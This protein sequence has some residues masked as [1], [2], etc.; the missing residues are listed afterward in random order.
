MQT[1]KRVLS[2]LLSGVMVFSLSAPSVYADDAV[3]GGITSTDGLCEHHPEHTEECGY[4][5][6][7]PEAPCTHEHTPDCYTQV[8]ECVHEHTPDCYPEAEDGASGE[9][10]REPENCAHVCSEESGCITKKLNCQHKHD[11]E[12]RYAP[13]IDG[14]PCGF[15]CEKCT[16]GKETEPVVPPEKEEEKPASMKKLRAVQAGDITN[17]GLEITASNP[18][19]GS[20]TAGEGT[21]DVTYNDETKTVTITMTNASIAGSIKVIDGLNAVVLLNGTNSISDDSAIGAIF[22]ETGAL[23]VNGQGTLNAVGRDY[24]LYGFNGITIETADI[25]ATSHTSS[26][27]TTAPI[28]ANNDISIIGSTI[29]TICPSNK[30]EPPNGYGIY[31]HGSNNGNIYISDSK[32]T[33]DCSLTAIYTEGSIEI[34]NTKIE[35]DSSKP[36]TLLYGGQGVTINN[37]TEITADCAKIVI[38]AI[39]DIVIDNSSMTINSEQSNGLYTTGDI[40]VQNGASVSGTCYYPTIYATNSISINNSTVNA[41]SNTNGIWTDGSLKVENSSNVTADG[42]YTGIG[43]LGGITI[44]NSAVEASGEM[45]FG[46]LT[47]SDIS[48][49]GDKTNV[50][51]KN[52]GDVPAVVSYGGNVDISGGV[53]NFSNQSDYV[54]CVNIYG[55]FTISGGQTTITAPGNSGIDLS[56]GTKVEITGGELTVNSKMAGIN[57]PNDSVEI[58]AGKVDITST[59]YVGILGQSV[60]ISGGEVSV[61]VS[62]NQQPFWVDDSTV[63]SFTGGTLILPNAANNGSIKVGNEEFYLVT[64]NAQNGTEP[65]SALFKKDEPVTPEEPR[66]E[67]YIFDGWYDAIS[68]G[69]KWNLEEDVVTSHMTLYAHWTAIQH[70]VTVQADEHGTASASPTS[71]AQGE[72][73]TLTATPNSGYHFK[74]WQVVS[75]SVTISNNSFTMPAGDVTVKAIFEKDS[76]GSSGGSIFSYDGDDDEDD[77]SSDSSRDSSSTPVY[78]REILTGGG[79]ALSGNRVHQSARLTVTK[80]RLHGSGDCTYCDQIR[81]WRRQ[82]RVIAIYDVAL[83]RGFRGT[84]TLTFPVPSQ[85][86]GKTLTVVHCLKDK[87]DTFDVTASGGK[88]TVT[89]DSLSPFAILDS[90]VPD[91]LDEDEGEN[92][93]TGAC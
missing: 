88:V 57:A 14:T 69:E 18:G 40:I 6:G 19:E 4:T 59:E 35:T 37:R 54:P 11:G 42:T 43:A 87:L 91:G 81:Q 24:A 74:E 15:V 68:G 28:Q 32:I 25:T 46:L 2:L 41:S 60:K 83:S 13:A 76:S 10:E 20:Y 8:T 33:T 93:N 44:D 56:S 70:N 50:Q 80:D 17:T 27:H 52:T 29:S 82:G 49:K 67:N 73:I 92:P 23:T 38:S 45:Q 22:V 36:E 89:V 63:S 78:G 66:R 30:S 7:T 26:Q 16:N 61:T 1:K 72:E 58:S 84:V 3:G 71:A 34:S 62:E 48:I 9:Q 47:E 85:Y 79:V 64:F 12:C 90:P 77:D 75:G 65:T 39:S 51:A 31:I 53:V 55:E 21:V 86:N 5:E